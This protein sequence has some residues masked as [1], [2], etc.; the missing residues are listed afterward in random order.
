MVRRFGSSML[1]LLCRPRP[2]WP[3]AA[4]SSAE[5]MG[6]STVLDK[7]LGECRMSDVGCRIA[8]LKKC[9]RFQVSDLRF[10]VSFVPALPLDVRR[11]LCP[12]GLASITFRLRPSFGF[13]PP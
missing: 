11:W 12:A 8:D 2:P 10:Q 6:V 9:F 3:T 1:D 5:T 4:S 13:C 7:L